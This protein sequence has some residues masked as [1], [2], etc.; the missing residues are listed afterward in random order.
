VASN[1]GRNSKYEAHRARPLE[2]YYS[3]FA[4]DNSVQMVEAYYDPE[5][6]KTVPGR[7]LNSLARGLPW[8]R[9]RFESHREYSMASVEEVLG[10]HFGEAKK[11]QATWLESTI[12]LNRGDHFEVRI[13]PIEAQFAPAFGICAN[14]FDGDGN[15]DLFLAQNFFDVQSETPRYDAGRGLL[16]L[17]D[18]QGGFRAVSGQESGI[19]IYG[20]QRGAA[21]CDFD[22]DGRIDLAVT[23]NASQTKLYRNTKAKPGLRV[24]LQGTSGNPQALGA[25]VRLRSSER[26]GPAQ[27]IHAGSG[28]WSQDGAVQVL[29]RLPGGQTEVSIEVRWP[30]GKVTTHTVRAE[31]SEVTISI[32]GSFSDGGTQL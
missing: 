6:Q 31:A 16:L 18:G 19:E 5:L 22:G 11:L 14:D 20:E 15:E 12:F 10:E 29:A 9:A 23:Q 17:G 32:D 30:G 3:D 2:I 21:A 4:A 25:V 1:W 27:E 13:L 7:Q 28:Y 24:R 8:V 26:A